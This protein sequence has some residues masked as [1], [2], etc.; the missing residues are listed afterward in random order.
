LVHRKSPHR[1]GAAATAA[2][3]IAATVLASPTSWETDLVQEAA[4]GSAGSQKEHL[5][6]RAWALSAEGESSGQV[7]SA[8]E[9]TRSATDTAGL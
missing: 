2:I 5:A 1:S 6:S 3:A 4:A 7:S 9:V 8:V